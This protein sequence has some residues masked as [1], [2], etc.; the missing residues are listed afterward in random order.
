MECYNGVSVI[1]EVDWSS[2]DGVFA[3]D[4]CL[5]GGGAMWEDQFCH[6]TFP[7]KFLGWHINALELLTVV[8]VTKLWGTNWKGLRI[9]IYCD[10]EASVTVINSGKSKDR[11]MLA[12]LREL[13]YVT[14]TN[15]FQVRAIHI[16]GV[17]NR[18]PDSLSRWEDSKSGER[19]FWDLVR[20]R[21][22]TEVKVRTDLFLLN[23]NWSFFPYR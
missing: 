2:P 22:V 1:P 13:A 14:A 10:N 7:G 9:L 18:V 21:S 16:K 12:C 23:D 8:V 6:F 3:S 5:T 11:E 19:E 15:E 4:A 20:G 17:E